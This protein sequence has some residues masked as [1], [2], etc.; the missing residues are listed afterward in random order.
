MDSK[1]SMA[2]GSPLCPSQKSAELAGHPNNPF[3]EEDEPKSEDDELKTHAVFVLSQLR[4]DE[5]IP[6]L[7]DVARNNRNW[8][9]RSSALFWLGQSG[10]PRAI[11]LF[12][13]ILRP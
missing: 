2:R 9:V 12:E 6:Q 13:S 7:L 11:D 8:R 4:R 3:A 5:G 10:D 1:R